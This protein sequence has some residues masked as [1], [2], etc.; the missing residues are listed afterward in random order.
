MLAGTAI[1]QA[2]FLPVLTQDKQCGTCGRPSG[3]T[4]GSYFYFP[5]KV[6]ST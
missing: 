4:N 2:G 5:S 6:V 3:K 1:V